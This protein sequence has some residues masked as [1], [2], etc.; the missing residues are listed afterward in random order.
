M[1]KFIYPT[2]FMWEKETIRQNYGKLIIEPLERGYGVTIGNALRRVLLSSI[3]GIAITGLRIKF[4]DDKNKEELVLNEFST[5][6][7]MTED[8]V[9]IVLNIKQIALKSLV[10]IEDKYT[11]VTEITGKDEICADD[12]IKDSKIEVINKDLHIAT[13]DPKNTYQFELDITKGFGYLPVEKMKLMIKEK[14]IPTGTIFLDG[15]YSPVRKVTFHVENTRVEQFVDYEKLILEVWTTGAV[16]PEESIKY[17]CELLEKQFKLIMEGQKVG[18]E[19]EVEEM[20][21]WKDDL[22]IPITDLKLS[23]RVYNA[24]ENKNIKTLRDLL[25]T[26][27]E[28]LEGMKNLGKKSLEEI[29][30]ALKKRGYVLR[31]SS[32]LSQSKEKK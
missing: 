30:K 8:V 23:T 4:K 3:P 29:E 5:V 20:K 16:T 12:L 22:D 1:K 15:L 27:I 10:D 28:E 18:E 11:V 13:V 25:N 26:P 9:E 6:K 21:E 31:V 24:L 2:K 19:E 7:G 32:E 17:S 14:N